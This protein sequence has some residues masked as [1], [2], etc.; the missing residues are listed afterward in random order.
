MPFPA[1][2][3]PRDLK[4]AQTTSG[5]SA[6]LR[7]EEVAEPA[8]LVRREDHAVRPRIA[9]SEDCPGHPYASVPIRAPD[10]LAHV[11]APLLGPGAPVV[12][13]REE[14][15][16]AV[17]RAGARNGVL[18]WPCPRAA[19]EKGGHGRSLD[20]KPLPEWGG[21]LLSA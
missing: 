16:C 10:T 2:R 14:Q 11:E 8:S 4:R 7:D 5:V 3:G 12:V 19:R 18:G 6:R 20:W 1:P 21:Y 17:V 13:F 9:P 15:N